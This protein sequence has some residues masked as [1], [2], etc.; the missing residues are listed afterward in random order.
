MTLLTAIYCYVWARRQATQ[1]LIQLMGAPH[2][3]GRYPPVVARPETAARGVLVAGL[4][5]CHTI[6]G[7]RV[8]LARLAW[9][10]GS[11]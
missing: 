9:A 2:W 1:S 7:E 6:V 4:P 10:S 8:E 3:P 11:T 5:D